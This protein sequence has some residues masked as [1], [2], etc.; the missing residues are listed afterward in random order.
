MALLCLHDIIYLDP[1]T[2][3]IYAT[4]ELPVQDDDHDSDIGGPERNND[5]AKWP[6]HKG[7]PKMNG[8][9]HT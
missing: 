1:I 6:V 9:P 3:N 8:K 5:K 2:I 4:G 7:G